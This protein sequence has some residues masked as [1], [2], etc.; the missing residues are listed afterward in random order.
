MNW[1]V[2]LPNNKHIANFESYESSDE[3]FP[4]VSNCRKFFEERLIYPKKYY[5][6]T[7]INI[8]IPPTIPSASKFTEYLE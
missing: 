4:T 5:S 2:E 3:E 6:N 7:A 8:K 1:I